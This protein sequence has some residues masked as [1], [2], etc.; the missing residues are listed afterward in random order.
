MAAPKR[1]KA[2]APIQDIPMPNPGLIGQAQS[3]SRPVR[4]RAPGTVI[5]DNERSL[6]RFSQVIMLCIALC[7]I[8]LSIYRIAF[9][10]DAS[11]N[12]FAVLFFG[13]ML[14]A[15]IA[16]GWI[17]VQ[18]RANDHQLRDVQDY[19]LGI[20]FFFSTVGAV[21]GARFMIGLFEDSEFFGSNVLEGTD[22]WYPNGYGVY[23]QT[24]ALLSVMM[25]QYR[26][27]HHFKGQT[28]FGW[29]IASYAPMVVLLGAGMN[30]WLRWS[31]GVVSYELGFSLIVLRVASMEM[32]LRSNNSINLT[33]IVI[34]SGLTPLLFEAAHSGNLDDSAGKGGALGR[35]SVQPATR[36][37]AE[38]KKRMG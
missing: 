25:V 3:P 16:I 14:S 24:I 20:G 9:D 27:L 11:N 23:V 12:D 4:V 38:A 31:G 18:S 29:A 32:A 8:W 26:L 33:V 17:E 21:W 6:I 1:M 15:L 34:A 19:M 36:S 30:T 22:D 37:R 13:G 28:S 7:A 5:D 2:V 35:G 10:E